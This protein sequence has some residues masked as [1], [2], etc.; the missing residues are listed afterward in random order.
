MAEIDNII[1]PANKEIDKIYSSILSIAKEPDSNNLY[2][3]RADSKPANQYYSGAPIQTTDR[4]ALQERNYN[5]D[6]AYTRLNDGTYIAKYDTYKSG[7]DNAEFAAQTQST[8][9]KW[10]NGVT[11]ALGKT[12]TAILG[13]TAGVVYSAGKLIQDG[14]ITSIYDNEFTNWMDDLNTKMDYNL[15]NY[16]TKQETEKNLGGQLLTS[17]FWADKVLGG[18]SFTAGAIVSE[19]IW[20]Y[21]TGGASI[22]SRLARWGTESL[23]AAKVAQ[24]VAKYKTLL[25][26]PLLQAYKAGNISKNTAMALGKTGDLF[27]TARFTMTSAGYEA[28]IEALQYKNEARENFYDNFYNINGRQPAQEDIDAFEENLANASNAVFGLNLGIVGSSNVLM[29]GS[30]FNLKNPIK[31]GIGEF[32]EKKAF[33]RG[34]TSVTDDLGK[35]IYKPIEASKAQRISRSIYD[36]GKNPLREGL[37]EEGGQGV[38]NKTANKWIENSYNPQ[39][40]TESADM[41][42]LIYESL[43]EQFGTKEGW[44]ENGV[45][46]I[47]GALGG[48][49][50]VVSE[51]RQRQAENELRIAG[52]NTFQKDVI[53]KRFLLM[54]QMNAFKNEAVS[55]AQKG[56]VSASKI[57]N[58][59]VLYANLN[60]KYQLGEDVMDAVNEASIALSTMTVDQFKE[61]GVAEADIETFK[62][63]VINK[64]SQTA[65]EFLTNRRYA[66][67]I[68]GRTPLVGEQNITVGDEALGTN[69]HE[70]LIQSLT[71]N[72]TAANSANTIM[73]DIH[74]KL[75]EELGTE[76]TNVLNTLSQLKRQSATI[77]GQTTKNVNKL[78]ALTAERDRLQSQIVAV[79]NAPRE[80]EGDRVAG[81][82]LGQLNIRL[83]EV[84]NQIDNLNTQ[85]ESTAQEINTQTQYQKNLANIDLTQVQDFTYIGVNDLVDLNENLSNFRNLIEGFKVANPQRYEYLTDLLDEYSQADDIFMSNQAST[86]ALSSGNLKLRNINN[87]LSKKLSKG[88]TMDEFTQEW[89][90]DVLQKYQQNK[91]YTLD[92][93]IEQE[94]ISE[95]IYTDFVD[96]GNVPEEIIS[97]LVDK[98]RKGTTLSPRE[99]AIY[100]DRTSEIND[101]LRESVLENVTNEEIEIISTTP[102]ERSVERLNNLL[103]RDYNSLS[104]IGDNYSDLMLQ[105]PTDTE[106]EEYRRLLRGGVDN[107]RFQLLKEKLGNWRLLDSAVAEEN[108]SVA[109]LLDLI[110]QL[111]TRIE[112]ED[113]KDTQTEEDVAQT[114]SA[115]KDGVTSTTVRYDLGQ[116]TLANATVQIIKNKGIYKFSHIKM[117]TIINRLGLAWNSPSLKITDA[118]GKPLKVTENSFN[119]YKQGTV[120][121]IDNTKI[122]IGA[123]NTLEIKEEDYVTMR[124]A[125]NMHVVVPSV[126]WSYFDVYEDNNGIARKMPSDFQEDINP[127]L[128]YN[129]KPDSTLGFKIADDDFNKQLRDRVVNG[130]RTPELE[131]EIENQL[132]IYITYQGQNVSVLKATNDNVAPDDNFRLLRQAAKDAFLLNPLNPKINASVKSGRIFIGS[133]EIITENLRSVSRPITP[134]AAQ[135]VISTGYIENGELTLSRQVPDVSKTY[136]SRVNDAKKVPVIVFKKGAY[137]IAYPVSLI[138]YA[139]D[140][141]ADINSIIDNNSLSNPEKVKLINQRIID[142]GIAA[143]KR[144][145]FYDEAKIEEIRAEFAA[146]ETFV[147]MAAFSSPNYNF[148]NLPI[149]ISLNIDLTN[150]DRTVS[151]A[152]LEIKT[153]TIQ[154]QQQKEDKYSSLNEIEDRLSEITV[155][156]GTDYTENSS[157]KYVNSKGEIVED[158]VYTNA[159]DEGNLVSNPT[160]QVQKIANLKILQQAFSAPIPKTVANALSPQIIDEVNYL[161]KKYSFYKNQTLPDKNTADQAREENTCG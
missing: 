103:K 149:D 50:G 14:S 84:E 68:I 132:K 69:T 35:T 66:E 121:Y 155:E 161:L 96:N 52:Q 160:S 88:A 113:V 11:K 4:R 45:G 127:Q 87:W 104:Y 150:L 19:G 131:K 20:A 153:D 40:T 148:S 138:K 5:I 114:V 74:A 8:T 117:S 58:D 83:L 82:E 21:A 31:T 53:G 128:I 126:N 109:D 81:A 116:N 46:L 36:Y 34:I 51:N 136:L 139:S 145:D 120:F 77:K 39:F 24:G 67:Y 16:Y 124:D 130:Q 97:S 151:D 156:L 140:S 33:G 147:S 142:T 106:I 29:L 122:N 65:K 28:S 94:P 157:T 78:K 135:Q 123:G 101:Q 13:G 43:G 38:I 18:L 93:L 57:A 72:L 90:T 15:P 73:G 85:L 141:A 99:Q 42:G 2:T 115:D 32:I 89:L 17:N 30:I 56:N 134:E 60:H 144:L 48:T 59:G 10:F 22:G 133:P 125:F 41:S 98:T 137:N 70:A 9:N 76:Q 105:K 27:N 55:E 152:K 100:N 12:G 64:Y 44:V 6:D 107:D 112:Q 7:R 62:E 63:D 54:N 159:F 49:S 23:G 75:S 91:V 37:Y 26:S 129:I 61:A 143:D 154:L 111:E 1:T 102:L 3:P 47:I 158:T 110:Q 118:K 71:W 119:N 95:D 86:I 92:R 25:K 79:Q 80:T 146:N 108:Q